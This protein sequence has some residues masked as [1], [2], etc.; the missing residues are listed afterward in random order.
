MEGYH[1]E[2]LTKV[3]CIFTLPTPTMGHHSLRLYRQ[4]VQGVFLVTAFVNAASCIFNVVQLV[5]GKIRGSTYIKNLI[6]RFEL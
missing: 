5:P 6:D 3:P 1:S 4:I 2:K